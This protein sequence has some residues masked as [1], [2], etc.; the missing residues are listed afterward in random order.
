MILIAFCIKCYIF[1][2]YFLN[3]DVSFRYAFSKNIA[4]LLIDLDDYTR[5]MLYAKYQYNRDGKIG[6]GTKLSLKVL[7]TVTI[8]D[9]FELLDG[10]DKDYK[11]YL[12]KQLKSKTMQPIYDIIGEYNYSDYYKGK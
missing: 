2:A 6:K 9:L 7:M 5:K 10:S 12:F 1:N 11:N 4:N 3:N 8:N